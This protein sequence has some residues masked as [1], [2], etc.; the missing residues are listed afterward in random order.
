MRRCSVNQ[1]LDDHTL[2]LQFLS[3]SETKDDKGRT[4]Y[5]EED[6]KRAIAARKAL[7]KRLLSAA[8]VPCSADP[9]THQIR[10]ALAL[11]LTP[12][13]GWN[14][15][16]IVFKFRKRGSRLNLDRRMEVTDFLLER[17]ENGLT[18]ERAVECAAK[19]FR[20]SRRQIFALRIPDPGSS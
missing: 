15:R 6:S 13:D 1:S 5:F 2:I 3:G 11:L 4:V 14:E 19:H 18:R 17:E 8:Y 10:Q 16:K 7:F 9:L 20:L 12:E